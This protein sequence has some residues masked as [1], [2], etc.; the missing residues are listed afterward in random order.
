M[1]NYASEYV[2]LLATSPVIDKLSRKE[3]KYTNKAYVI[4]ICKSS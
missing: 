2:P 4:L 1:P 3:L